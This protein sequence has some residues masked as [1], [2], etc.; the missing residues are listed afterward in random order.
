MAA[1]APATA[2]SV[3]AP[4]AIPFSQPRQDNYA[5]GTAGF[6]I[7]AILLAITVAVLWVARRKGWGGIAGRK[8]ETGGEGHLVLTQRLRLS[9]TCSAFV[10][11]D[12]ESRMLVVESR[13]TVQISRLDMD[14][15]PS[16]Q[17]LTDAAP[18][19]DTRRV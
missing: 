9:P 18:A 8:V 14:A 1:T 12:G 2:A 4:S 15:K 11:S 5:Q 13:H 19:S 6:V 7:A 16:I 17:P 10:L 3:G